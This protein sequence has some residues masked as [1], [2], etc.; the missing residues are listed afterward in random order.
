MGRYSGSG[1]GKATLEGNVN[2][3]KETYTYNV[4]FER[5]NE[6][7]NFI[8][9]L[10]GARCVGYLLDQIRLHGESPELV[11]EVVRLAKK[12]RHCNTVYQLSNCRGRKTTSKQSKNSAAKSITKKSSNGSTSGCRRRY[13]DKF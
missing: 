12:T 8:P 3:K 13:G 11:S 5:K 7:H 2:G 1:T 4:T 10:W 6:D 9:P